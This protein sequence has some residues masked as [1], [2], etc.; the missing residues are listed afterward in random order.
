MK[1]L[2]IAIGTAFAATAIIVKMMSG[3]LAKRGI[4]DIPNE[5]SSHTVQTPRG[6]GL[7][8]VVVFLFGVVV[9]AQRGLLSR[10]LCWALVGGGT[11]VALVGLMD[12]CFKVGRALR[13]TI[14]LAASGWALVCLGGMSPLHLEGVRVQWGWAGQVVALLG[15]TWMINLYNFMDGI[16]G[17][18]G[19]EALCVGG[20]GSALL[21]WVGLGGYGFCAGIL[22]AAAAGFLVWNWPPARIFMG[23]V[24]SG[25]TGFVFG[26]LTI[27][28]A[29][30]QPQ[31]LWAWLILLSVFIVDATVT[32]VKRAMSGARWYEA[33]RSHAYQ[34][35]ARA[36]HSHARI[37][38][39]I[40]A[41]NVVWLFPLAWG[42]CA[43]PT[44]API[45][46]VI[47]AGPLVYLAFRYG[48]G[49]GE[50]FLVDERIESETCA[51]KYS[52]T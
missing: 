1:A 5:R 29:K 13:L 3:Y 37:T 22:G 41:I 19:V 30:E 43:Y 11:A 46:T 2:V 27:A 16:D 25:F 17:L 15:V 24:G 31:L 32:L 7:G 47:A 40:A 26:V 34:R 38:V 12:D 44:A 20:M 51:D 9:L 36:W 45:F 18:A 49:R 21:A 28:S 52:H 42:A 50:S 4:V 10:E 8:I 6:G 35:M 39:A 14:H 23:D 33:H 48:A